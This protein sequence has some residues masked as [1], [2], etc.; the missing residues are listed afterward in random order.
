MAVTMPNL[1]DQA[2]GGTKGARTR[3]RLLDAA[4]TRFSA[5]GFRRTSVSDI[6]RD[7]GVTPAA[8]YAYFANKDALFKAAVDADTAALLDAAQQ[9]IEGLNIR[10]A[11][12]TTVSQLRERLP[13]HPL[14]QRVLAGL[15]PV[16]AGQLMDLPALARVVDTMAEALREAQRAGE[17]RPDVGPDHFAVG[18]QVLILSA[19]M[20]EIQFGSDER[21]ML[22]VVAVLDAA[23][24]PM[25]QL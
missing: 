15:E 14:A 1:G 13:E 21:R 6:S 3:R 23:M 8:A 5:D 10:D 11:Y 22:G 19:L 17:I 9:G 7:A 2:P 25:P 18:L 12:W 4:I 16:I 20:A 24:R